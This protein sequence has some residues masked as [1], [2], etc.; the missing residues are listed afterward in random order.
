MNFS[1]ENY[2]NIKQEKA[3]IYLSFLKKILT[4]LSIKNSYL[5]K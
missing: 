3:L 1:I 4:K 5:K 2:K